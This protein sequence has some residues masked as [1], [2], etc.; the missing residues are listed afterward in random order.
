MPTCP[1]WLLLVPGDLDIMPLW[2]S[3]FIDLSSSQ[4]A[5][6]YIGRI[7]WSWF[8][9]N[10]KKRFIF[11][12][13]GVLC[14]KKL[15]LYFDLRGSS[16]FWWVRLSG[17]M[18]VYSFSWIDSLSMDPSSPCYTSC[19][20]QRNQQQVLFWSCFWFATTVMDLSRNQVVLW[21]VIGLSS[22]LLG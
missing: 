6:L 5:W 14:I 15:C 11:P 3:S 17:C 13:F 22:R 20:T 4:L 19:V 10:G 18:F 12:L 7:G 1:F 16:K 8:T 2:Y 21:T 9:W